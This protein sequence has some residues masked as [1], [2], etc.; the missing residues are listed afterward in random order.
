MKP[1]RRKDIEQEVGI[2]GKWHP[3][4]EYNGYLYEGQNEE[5]PE[6]IIG[7]RPEYFTD[8]VRNALYKVLDRENLKVTEDE[9]YLCIC[10]ND[11]FTLRYGSYEIL[12]KCT[13]CGKEAS[14]YS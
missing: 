4:Y 11:T 12:A 10:G 13:K 14:A 8:S 2:S 9:V 3:L 7:I 1:K 6:Y 5:E